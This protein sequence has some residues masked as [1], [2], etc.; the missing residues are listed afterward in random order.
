MRMPRFK[1]LPEDNVRRDFLDW[2]DFCAV[3]A[4]EWMRDFVTVAC[5]SSW[6]QGQLAALEWRDVD[7]AAREITARGETTKNGRPHRIPLTGELWEIFERA[8][9]KRAVLDRGCPPSTGQPS[10]ICPYVFHRNGEPF[11]LRGGTSPAR[12]AWK[13]AC[14]DAGFP[15]RTLHCLRRSG[16]RNMI[17]AGV[18]PMVAMKVSGHRTMDMLVRYRI[19]DLEDQREAFAKTGS[20][21]TEQPASKIRKLG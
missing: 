7:M 1:M 10:T 4:P 11:Q 16:I 2:P 5:L 20:F 12:R 19:V 17:R 9:A 18:D 8:W 14:L 13:K 21:L 3:R 6:R 15:G